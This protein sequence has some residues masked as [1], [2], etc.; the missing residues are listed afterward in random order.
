MRILTANPPHP[1]I[2]SVWSSERLGIVF[3]DKRLKEGPSV[4]AL[5]GE[6]LS[7]EEEALAIPVRTMANQHSARAP[8]AL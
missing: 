8:S 7:H 3:R 5:W 4:R 2:G 6:T 1:A